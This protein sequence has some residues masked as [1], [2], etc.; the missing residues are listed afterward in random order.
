MQQTIA[1]L[2]DRLDAERKGAGG[3]R[4]EA[5]ERDEVIHRLASRRR[6]LSR[7]GLDL[8][9]GHIV[10]ATNP[11]PVY[12]GR[13]GLTD[14]AGHRL[15]VDWR[16]PMAEPFFRAPHAN[17][18]GLRSRRRYRWNR[19]RINDYWDEVFTLELAAGA[20]EL[21]GREIG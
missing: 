13:L 8:C 19:G 1:D 14:D 20:D 17:P 15:L 4:Q 18:M 5:M 11:E 21:Q 10:S 9:L 3:T 16:S 12:V 2:S 7:F 6:A